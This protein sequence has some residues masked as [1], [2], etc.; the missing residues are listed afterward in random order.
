MKCKFEIIFSRKVLTTADGGID[1]LI[2]TPKEKKTRNIC[3]FFFFFADFCPL[4]DMMRSNT[5]K[6]YNGK[7]YIESPE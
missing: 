4:G 1:Y 3:L 7:N 6:R 2:S 5:N